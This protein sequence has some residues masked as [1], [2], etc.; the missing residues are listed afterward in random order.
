VEQDLSKPNLT[1]HGCFG[2]F[3]GDASEPIDFL[4]DEW[5]QVRNKKRKDKKKQ[6]NE[7]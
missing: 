1:F 5:T 4:S 2:K 7:I 3:A 6:E